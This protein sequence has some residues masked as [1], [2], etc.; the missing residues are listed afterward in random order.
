MLLP[1]LLMIM[2]LTGAIAGLVYSTRRKWREH[3]REPGT[4]RR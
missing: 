2:I 3:H 1:W 4:G